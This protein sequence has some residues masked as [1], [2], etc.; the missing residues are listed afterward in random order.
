MHI[1]QVKNIALFFIVAHGLTSHAQKQIATAK[2]YQKDFPT[3]P[4]SDPNP[5]PVSTPLYPYYRFDGFTNTPVQQSWKVVEL[6]NEYIKVMILPEVGG[7][8]WTA[9]EKSTNQ[10]FIYY[11]HT[12]KFRDISMRGPWTSGGLEPN[13]GTIGHTPNCATPVDYIV[14][15]NADSSVSCII[16]VLDLLTRSNWRMEIK[17]EKDKAYFTT[18]CFWYNSTPIEQPYYHWVNGGFKAGGNLEFIFP[19]THFIGHEGEFND[20]P[21]DKKNRKKISFYNENDFGG[22][23][24]YHVFGKYANFSGGYWHDDAL[25]TVRYAPDGDKAGKKIWI[26]GLSGQGMIWEKLLTDTDGQYVEMQSGRLVNQGTEKSAFTPFKHHGFAPYATDIWK[27]YWYP[28]LKT[29]GYV[30]ANEYGALN[31]KIEKDWIKIYFSPVQAI[32]DKL[33]IKQGEKILYSKQLSLKPLKTFA[34][35]IRTEGYAQF[36]TATLG[37]NKLVYQSDSKANVLSR[38]VETPKDFDWKGL[39][40]LYVQGKENMDQ[41]LY[42]A[43]EEKLLASLKID[44]NYLPSLVKMAELKYRNVLYPEALEYAKKALSIDTHH[45]ASNYYYGLINVQLGNITDAKDAFNFA[46]LSPEYRSA[47][48]TALARIYLKEKNFEKSWQNA[49]KAVS[50]NRY[51][52]DALQLQAVILRLQNKPAQAAEVLKN[53]LQLDPLNHFARFERYIANPSEKYKT[54]FTSLI[55]NEM[56]IQTYLELGIWY[57]TSGNAS[58]AEKVFLLS[59][60]SVETMYWLSFLQ[61]K[62]IDFSAVK[63]DF[64]FPFRSESVL[65]IEELSKRQD[66]WIILYHLG[67]MYKDRN[68]IET[69]IL[70]FNACKDKPGYAPFYASRAELKKGK[71]DAACEADLK[72]ALALDNKEWRYHKLLANYYLDHQQYDKALAIT[73]PFYKS[74]PQSFIMGML[75]AKTLMLNK[76]Y[77]KADEVLTKIDIIPFEGATDGRELYREAKLMQAAEAMQQ[78]KYPDAMRFVAQ[79]RQWP[80]NLG[81]GKPYD[82][83]I[84]LRLEDW[85]EYLSVKESGKNADTLLQRIIKFDPHIDNTVP[86]F[87]QANTL[88]TVWAYE[89][90]N[91]KNDGQQWLDKQIKLYPENKIAGW[92]K[93]MFEK[94]GTSSLAAAEKDAN[95]RIIER[96]IQNGSK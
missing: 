75:Y 4:F 65:V 32:N 34:D 62:K 14:R 90:L 41:K 91:R 74:H 33:E 89:G 72:K 66:D 19:G 8:I 53:I 79:S 31:I 96:L 2:E 21:V 51:N 78:K 80:D 9:I 54:D 76:M 38:P 94:S 68:R 18:E 45:G 40:G 23:K 49:D 60:T 44:P 11:N 55:R 29:K 26:W 77:K 24:S 57:Y 88:I 20:W 67:L 27:E 28:V 46:V 16:G 52:M 71:D 15:T 81:V 70:F 95:V 42:P 22:Y 6:E 56:P 1:F 3:Y 58:E 82:K 47:A 39:Y 69:S 13:F 7:K 10:P 84:D 73:E 5:I 92:S 87:V 83:D 12:I 37:G 61:D 85:M 50:F 48:Y 93:A 63:P 36:I 25:G 30:E 64:T 43:A 35:S 17:L 86:N 59:P